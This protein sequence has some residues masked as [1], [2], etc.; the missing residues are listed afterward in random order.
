MKLVAAIIAQQYTKYEVKLSDYP[1]N[2]N[3]VSE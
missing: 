3:H 1:T 2:K